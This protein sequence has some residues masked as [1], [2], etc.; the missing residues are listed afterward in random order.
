[1]LRVGGW[2]LSVGGCEAWVGVKR[3]WVLSVGGC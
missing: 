2:V 1:M 3:G